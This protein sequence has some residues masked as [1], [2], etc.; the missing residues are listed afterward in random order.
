MIIHKDIVL[1]WIIVTLGLKVF[2]R[3][4]ETCLVAIKKEV[5]IDIPTVRFKGSL[6]WVLGRVGSH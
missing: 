1:L 6:E 5:D 4:A 3:R 2:R